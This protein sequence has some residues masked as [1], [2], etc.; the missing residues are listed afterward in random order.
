MD[1]R[2]MIKI[3]RL[4]LCDDVDGLH[5]K[6]DNLNESLVG[7]CFIRSIDSQYLDSDLG[8]RCYSK[9]YKLYNAYETEKSKLYQCE[10]TY[11]AGRTNFSKSK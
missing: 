1:G 10:Q 9:S 4:W 7:F 2:Q 6:I 8:A 11:K 3:E 5:V